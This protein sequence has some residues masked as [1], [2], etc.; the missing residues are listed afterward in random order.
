MG[1]YG[2][3]NHRGAKTTV[4]DCR[5]IDVNRWAREGILVA[6]TRRSGRWIWWEDR[7]RIREEASIGY[8]VQT[9]DRGTGTVRLTYT[10]RKT[11]EAFDYRIGLQTTRPHLG[12]VRWWFTCPLVKDGRACRRRCG[13]LYLPPTGK[14]CGCR[15]C[16]DLTY[17]SCR[18]GHRMDG[19]WRLLGAEVGMDPRIVRRI[20]NQETRDGRN[21]REKGSGSK[22]KIRE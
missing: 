20:M 9:T 15:S 6:G 5:W 17:Q 4:E 2:S 19:I 11:A 12:G 7:D 14:Y 21:M 1:G 16:Y 18:E 10:I 3:G 8:E 22:A 13:K